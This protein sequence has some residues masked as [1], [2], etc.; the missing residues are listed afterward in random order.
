MLKSTRRSRF[1][2]SLLGTAALASLMSGCAAFDQFKG[3]V[4][5]TPPLAPIRIPHRYPRL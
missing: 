5:P 2:R 1:A 3:L 4:Q